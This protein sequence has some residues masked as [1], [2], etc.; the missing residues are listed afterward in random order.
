MSTEL[1]THHF[2]TF[3]LKPYSQWA[4]RYPSYCIP[5]FYALDTSSTGSQA[6]KIW[7]TSPLP[8]V[9]V[10]GDGIWKCVWGERSVLL[11]HG[12][13]Q[14]SKGGTWNY[15][16]ISRYQFLCWNT[17][18]E[19]AFGPKLVVDVWCQSTSLPLHPSGH[20]TPDTQ[21]VLLK[22]SIAL[23]VKINIS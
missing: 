21:E 5:S 2:Q 7:S 18:I 1:C 6:C 19:L 10:S 23:D 8:Q 12:G 20:E 3:S 17:A 22:A 13:N 15:H 16:K 14:K 11:S 4:V 9:V